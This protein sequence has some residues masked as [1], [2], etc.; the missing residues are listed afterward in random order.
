M[1]AG[2]SQADVAILVV[3]AGAGGFESGFENGGQTREH[4]LLLKALGVGQVIVAVNKMDLADWSMVRYDEISAKVVDFLMNV[5][6]FNE[7]DIQFIAL[8]GYTGDN[9]VKSSKKQ[10]ANWYKGPSLVDA[11]GN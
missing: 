4:A 5:A 7:T 3:D 1:V 2:T 9:L 8:S 6:G 10:E 11:L